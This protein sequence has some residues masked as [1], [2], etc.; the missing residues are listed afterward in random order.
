MLGSQGQTKKQRPRDESIRV[1]FLLRY[2]D[3]AGWKPRETGAIIDAHDIMPTLLGLCSIPIPKSV[4]GI[5]LS[6]HIAGGDDASDGSALLM[7]PHAFGQWTP[8]HHKGKEYRGL[9]T[10]RY[11]YVRD[12]KAPWL[13]YDNDADP[14]QMQNL[15]DDPKMAPIR[16]TLDEALLKKLAREGDAF[17]SGM[18]YI[19][20]WD[21][22]VDENG[23][24]PYAN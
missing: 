14:Y 3:L 4:E 10:K 8:M 13:F 11:T 16:D 18:D 2:P 21:Y 12:R 17:L 15:V 1:P 6:D 20:K 7:C 22:T 23:T 24:V 9:R 5:D 19:K